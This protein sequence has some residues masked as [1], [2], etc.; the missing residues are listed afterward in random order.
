MLKLLLTFNNYAHDLITGYFAALAWVGYRWYSFLP[1]NA[2]D[3]FKQQLKLALLFIILT[4][5]PRTIFFTTMELLPAQQKGLVM[6]LVFK[7]ILIFIVICFGIFYW[8]KQQDF[9]KKY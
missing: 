4:G 6:F 2:R 7:H 9:V 5:I 3:W 8:R 1:T